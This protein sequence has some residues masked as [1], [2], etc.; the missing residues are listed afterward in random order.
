MRMN[1]F[2]KVA[3]ML[4]VL[5]LILL[6]SSFVAVSQG[7]NYSMI[8]VKAGDRADYSTDYS[9]HDRLRIEVTKVTGVLVNLTM[10]DYWSNGTVTHTSSAYGNVSKGD[11]AELLV[12]G[13]LQSGDPLWQGS[14]MS[15][16]NTLSME[17]AGASRVVNELIHGDELMYWDQATGIFVKLVNPGGSNYTVI[18]TNMWGPTD[19]TVLI[20]IG[21]GAAAVAVVGAVALVYK[22]SRK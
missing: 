16:N 17:I 5:A 4:V 2:N 11:L 15:F 20:I 13:G 10:T 1:R 14:D 6:S 7:A 8:G 22:R 12:C 21:G 3:P 9:G 19:P 18:S